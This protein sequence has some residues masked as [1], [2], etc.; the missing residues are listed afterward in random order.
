MEKL[1]RAKLIPDTTEKGSALCVNECFCRK[2]WVFFIS[3]RIFGN[4]YEYIHW[5]VAV[6]TCVVI[7]QNYK[8]FQLEIPILKLF[9]AHMFQHHLFRFTFERVITRAI[10][11]NRIC[12][13]CERFDSLCT[14]Y[15]ETHRYRSLSSVR[16][17]YF[18]RDRKPTFDIALSNKKTREL[19][20]YIG[21]MLEYY[22][23]VDH[24]LKSCKG[25]WVQRGDCIVGQIPGIKNNVF[26]LVFLFFMRHAHDF[27]CTNSRSHYC[28]YYVHSVISKILILSWEDLKS[29]SP[30]VFRF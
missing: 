3:V 6:C 1:A 24:F 25:V 7:W 18:G 28:A 29:K 26:F 27:K 13:M 10:L 5:L 8:H 4:L 21:E 22:A 23:Q 17:R 20:F 19:Y 11:S 15:R 9:S 30:N 2:L 16:R 12:K 14:K